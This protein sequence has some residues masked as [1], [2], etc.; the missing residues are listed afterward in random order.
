MPT[1]TPT[2]G[3]RFCI[4]TLPSFGSLFHE[5]EV[6]IDGDWFAFTVGGHTIAGPLSS[7]RAIR[8]DARL[9]ERM[10][11]RTPRQWIEAEELRERRE[12][13]RIADRPR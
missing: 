4:G 8:Y 11:S 10:Q 7:V 13:A 1:R 3:A 2:K 6:R 12:T 5:Q 9:A